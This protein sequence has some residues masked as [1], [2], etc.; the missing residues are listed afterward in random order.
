MDKMNSDVDIS[1][2]D[3]NIKPAVES[4]YRIL[5][6]DAENA[7]KAALKA[8]AEVRT[9]ELEAD[10]GKTP[11]K[12]KVK[13]K[14]NL[15]SVKIT[16]VSLFLSAFISFI[17]E[18]TASSEQIIVTLMLLL[19]LILASILFDGIGVAVTS[20]D[21]TPIM[22]MAS[23]KIYGAKTAM[24]L[25]KNNEKVANVCNDVIGD[26]FGI[27]SGAC[28]A[29]IVAKIILTLGEGWQKWLTIGIS[30][31]VAALTIGGK[32]FLKNVAITNS[33]EFVMFVARIIAVFSPEERRRK[34]KQAEDRKKYAS[35]NGDKSNKVK[36]QDGKTRSGKNEKESAKDAAK[37]TK[38]KE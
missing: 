33:K 25:V 21:I 22:A 34:K 10:G 4:P 2:S 24:W 18:L 17:S 27:I 14:R 6:P 11:K 37:R 23:R 1:G 12:P 19:F 38:D 7:A 35:D 32:A 20:C 9:E 36:L 3:G 13:K 5:P 28:T 15:W 30:S 8:E 16:V 26:I 29:A 31:L